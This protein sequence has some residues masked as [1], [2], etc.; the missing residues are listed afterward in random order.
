MDSIL[1][2]GN[3]APAPGPNGD[4]STRLAEPKREPTHHPMAEL[5]P[6]SPAMVTELAMSELAVTKLATRTRH[7][8]ANK[9]RNISMVGGGG[10]QPQSNPI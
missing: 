1:L 6:L 2:S 9:A 3:M 7:K 10:V 4:R 8:V 5:V